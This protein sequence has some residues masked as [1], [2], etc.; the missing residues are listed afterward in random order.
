MVSFPRCSW[1]YPRAEEQQLFW[2]TGFYH[3]FGRTKSRA[4][5]RPGFSRS[6]GSW[7]CSLNLGGPDQGIW[8]RWVPDWTL[9]KPRS[10]SSKSCRALH[11][12]FAFANTFSFA[13]A[14]NFPAV[15]LAGTAGCTLDWRGRWSA[16]GF[17][18]FTGARSC[19]G[20]VVNEY[21]Q[22]AWCFVR[23][24]AG[25]IPPPSSAWWQN[26]LH[27]EG[28]TGSVHGSGFFFPEH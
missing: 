12:R 24:R 27:E 19:A 25:A 16:N 22:G 13:S 15:S 5:P 28:D 8:A 21:L 23:S 7:S 1:L 20:V 11:G 6:S 9:P 3:F 10:F 2:G 14:N 26:C 18:C 17:C 4:A